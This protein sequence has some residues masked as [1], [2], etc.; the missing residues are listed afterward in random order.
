MLLPPKTCD[1]SAPG[2]FL[3]A[4]VVEGLPRPEG[5]ISAPGFR[6]TGSHTLREQLLKSANMYSPVGPQLGTFWPL[7][8][9]IWRCPLPNGCKDQPSR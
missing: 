6:L 1:L 8:W 7:D 4:Q 9:V 5:G 3:R 2:L